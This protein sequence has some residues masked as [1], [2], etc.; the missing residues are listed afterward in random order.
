M[1]DQAKGANDSKGAEVRSISDRKRHAN[2]Q[3]AARSTGPRSKAGKGRSRWNAI[4]HGLLVKEVPAGYWPS[5]TDDPSLFE[6]L[7]EALV[8]HFDPVGPVEGMLVEFIA[9]CYWRQRRFQRAENAQI[10]LALMEERDSDRRSKEDT[11]DIGAIFEEARQSINRC[12]YVEA[13]L[14]KFEPQNLYWKE[15]ANEV[16]TANEKARE[17]TRNAVSNQ[18]SPELKVQL[19][20]AR[21][22]LLRRL[23]RYEF[24]LRDFH[25]RMKRVLDQDR[26]AKFA[27]HLVLDHF[28]MDNFLRYETAN[29]RQMYRALAELEH[30]QCSRLGDS[31]APR[32]KVSI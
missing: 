2:R 16:F 3:N 4:K 24:Y 11:P 30:L 27:Q 15:I 14:Q 7:M 6:F 22:T 20:K 29:R 32:R 10:R 12:G 9:Q 8:D 25:D 17:L 19:K 23:D 26:Q 28:S 5:I 1:E 18:C 31:V 13:D 21:T